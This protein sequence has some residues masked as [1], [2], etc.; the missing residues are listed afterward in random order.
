MNLATQG[1]TALHYAYGRS[2]T[3]VINILELLDVEG[4]SL[5]DIRNEVSNCMFLKSNPD[6]WH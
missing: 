1:D 5:K 4:V 6:I 2:S 3:E